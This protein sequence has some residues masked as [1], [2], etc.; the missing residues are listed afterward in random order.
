MC[1]LFVN[2]PHAPFMAV[3]LLTVLLSYPVIFL[4]VDEQKWT[5]VLAS[6]NFVAMRLLRGFKKSLNLYFNSKVKAQNSWVL[7][8]PF[9]NLG[10][11]ADNG[12]GMVSSM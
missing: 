7:D 8:A 5:I 10:S 3:Y 11:H 9:P 12:L 1:L 2:S 4:S 6:L